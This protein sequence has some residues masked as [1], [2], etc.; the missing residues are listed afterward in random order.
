MAIGGIIATKGSMSNMTK[1]KFPACWFYWKDWLD[2]KVQRMSDA[3]QGVYMRLLAY[4]WTG[5]ATQYSIQ[6]DDRGLSQALGISMRVWRLR[7]AEIQWSGDPLLVEENGM[8]IS[9]RLRKEITKLKARRDS[10]K[11][12]ALARRKDKKPVAQITDKDVLTC[13][14][15]LLK[16]IKACVDR[17][18]PFTKEGPKLERW[19]QKSARAID[20]L[21]RL[22]GVSFAEIREVLEYIRRS[23]PDGRWTGWQAVILSG[24]NLREKWD[25]IAA[26]MPGS[27]S[28]VRWPD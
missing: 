6:D 21:H 2:Y 24:D 9:K 5:T 13:V 10:G 12:S 4:I 15:I 3:A 17:R 25:K 1:E 27:G 26:Q 7:R 20:K 14:G 18:L 28:S 11:E 22:D 23:E 8:L 19:K 16:N